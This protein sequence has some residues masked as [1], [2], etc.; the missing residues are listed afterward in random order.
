MLMRIFILV[1]SLLLSFHARGQ[2][3]TDLR[4]TLQNT[5]ASNQGL[6]NIFTH[7]MM[8]RD[9]RVLYEPHRL[10]GPYF[11][12]GFEYHE[13]DFDPGAG[14]IKMNFDLL[15]D[16]IYYMGGWFRQDK[17]DDVDDRYSNTSFFSGGLIELMGSWNIISRDRF[18]IGLGFVL[19]DLVYQHKEI[20]ENGEPPNPRNSIVSGYGFYGG[21][22]LHSDILINSAWTAHLDF[23]R[24]FGLYHAK[25]DRLEREG[26]PSTPFDSWKL[27]AMI[28][29]QSGFF[30]H[31]RHHQT[32]AKTD[33]P[34]QAARIQLGVGFR[35]GMYKYKGET[36]RKDPRSNPKKSTF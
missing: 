10:R 11:T 32:I 28:L 36:H 9:S 8:I 30:V 17:I 6:H 3:R 35:L 23:F 21:G 31:F 26:Y 4:P 27:T 2:Y 33:L 16:L 22:V 12:L 5:R 1:F 18:T 25:K 20:D 14:R 24:G 19:Y 13:L 29:H 7:S 15:G 34:T